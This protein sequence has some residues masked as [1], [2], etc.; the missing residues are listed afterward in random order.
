VCGISELSDL[1][2]NLKMPSSLLQTC[3]NN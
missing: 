3:C 2:T 1:V